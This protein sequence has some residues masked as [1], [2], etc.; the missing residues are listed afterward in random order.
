MMENIEQF[1]KA[2]ERYGVP[3]ID[4]FQTVDLWEKRNIPSVVQC[5]MAVGRCGYLHPDFQGPFL[6]PRPSEDFR[7]DFNEQMGTNF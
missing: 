2:A 3:K 1:L 7:Q 6:G 5:I 4:L